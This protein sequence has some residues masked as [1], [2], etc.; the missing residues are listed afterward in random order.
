M[1]TEKNKIRLYKNELEK[2]SISFSEFTKTN[3]IQKV[4]ISKNKKLN[5]DIYITVS[6]YKEISLI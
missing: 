2:I 4:S 5:T 3:H 1:Y 6:F